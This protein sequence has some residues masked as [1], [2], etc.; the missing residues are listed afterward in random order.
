MPGFIAKKLCPQL[1]IIRGCFAKYREASSVVGIFGSLWNFKFREAKC[2]D[3]ITRIFAV[4]FQFRKI[5]REYDPDICAYGLD[6][7]YIDLTAYIQNRFR[8]GP[9]TYFNC[10]VATVFF[11]I[12]FRICNFAVE[13]ERIRYMGECVCR[14]PLVAENETCHL[15]DAEITEEMCTKCK[16]LCKIVRDRITFGVDVDEVRVSRFLFLLV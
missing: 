2:F 9:G 16:K 1:K 13:H 3:K 11:C 15:G 6:E 12:Y 5:L 4:N 8:I 10:C 7:A 14:L